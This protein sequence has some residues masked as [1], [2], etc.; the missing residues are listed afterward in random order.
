MP[1]S[2]VM[3]K[4]GAQPTMV[5]QRRVTTSTAPNDKSLIHGLSALIVS[6]S[7]SLACGRRGLRQIIRHL[8]SFS[9]LQVF[10]ALQVSEPILYLWQ[11]IP[12][13][14]QSS[15]PFSSGLPPAVQPCASFFQTAKVERTR[16]LVLDMQNKIAANKHCHS[17]RWRFLIADIHAA[18]TKKNPCYI[19]T[20]CPS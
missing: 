11:L 5:T 17:S 16:F 2:I 10:P 14:V 13:Y 18:E 20:K 12:S 6:L 1:F 4:V 8:F 19:G 15:S 7:S 9:V 3:Q